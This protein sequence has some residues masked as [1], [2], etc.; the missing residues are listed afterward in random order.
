[1]MGSH[2]LI[3]LNETYNQ[4][5]YKGSDYHGGTNLSSMEFS[6]GRNNN[7]DIHSV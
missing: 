3:N 7:S 1:M 4:G 2:L 6:Y 5:D